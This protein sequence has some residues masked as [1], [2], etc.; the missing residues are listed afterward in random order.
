MAAERDAVSADRDCEMVSV[1]VWGAERV[2]VWGRDAVGVPVL[3]AVG[4]ELIDAL[5]EKDVVASGV[6]VRESD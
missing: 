3:V 4:T 2:D 1:S 6:E 5:V